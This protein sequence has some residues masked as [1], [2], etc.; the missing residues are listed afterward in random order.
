MKKGTLK[1]WINENSDFASIFTK[2]NII[3][4]ILYALT[5]IHSKKLLHMDLK[6]QNIL[7]DKNL[8]PKIT[9]F[10]SAYNRDVY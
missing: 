2:I 8:I 3:L 1:N 5:F 10:G 9:D 7:M 4:Y 6:P